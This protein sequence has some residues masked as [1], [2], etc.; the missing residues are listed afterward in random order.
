MDAL[1][2]RADEIARELAPVVESLRDKL[3]EGLAALVLFGS[4][5]RGDAKE[6]SDWDLL[7]IARELPSRLL[8]RRSMLFSLMPEQWRFRTSFLAKTPE[9]FEQAVPPLYLDIALDGIVLR[10]TGGYIT[11][12][13]SGIQNMIR[14]KGL[15]RERSGRGWVWLR[16]AAPGDKGDAP[17]ADV[18][19]ERD[20]EYRVR[21]ARGF[22][23]EARE[24]MKLG[25][26][27]SCVD[28][29]VVAVENA[30]KG[31]IALWSPVPHTRWPD[32]AL[33]SMLEAQQ[34]P[35]SFCGE[36]KQIVGMADV[37][38][39][40]V[41]MQTDYGDETASETP[42]QLFE[43]KDARRAYKDAKHLVRAAK[44]LF[45]AAVSEGFEYG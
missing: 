13:L 25:R 41:H 26:W 33:V 37:F 24:D 45:K 1:R 34:I 14:E 8:E 15:F 10:D 44:A 35:E 3:G 20:A 6:E 5:A 29:A 36:V 2:D 17:V 27:R 30:L 42:W 22:L 9:E 43:R 4:R 7:L 11:G 28:G 23:R 39:H 38:R 40:E 12:K 31:V 19:S 16:Q 18:Y 32:Q 21:V